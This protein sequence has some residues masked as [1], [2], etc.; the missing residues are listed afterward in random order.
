MERIDSSVLTPQ[1]FYAT[2]CDIGGDVLKRIL[3]VLI[4]EPESSK[5]LRGMIK[6]RR[7]IRYAANEQ[8]CLDL[9]YAGAGDV[10][11]MDLEGEM[12]CDPDFATRLRFIS[13]SSFPIIGVASPNFK[14]TDSWLRAGLAEV[15]YKDRL[16][17][18]SLD[19]TI[20]HW[21]RHQRLQIRLSDANRRALHWWG[22]LVSALDQMRQRMEK[23]SSSL[24]AYLSLLEAAEG[25]IP[26]LRQQT[27]ANARKQLAEIDQLGQ[28]MD[29]AARTIQLEGIEK[30]KDQPTQGRRKVFTTESFV[31]SALKEE[32]RWSIDR[33]KSPDSEEKRRYGT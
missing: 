14:D 31:T 32:Q 1:G 29:V 17:P 20:R 2:L 33:S 27:V 11:L 26:S 15:I 4:A 23:T 6:K 5:F 10:M 25:E 3:Q 30:S 8:E 9:G 24:N 19:R 18:F 21:V 12:G 13:R 16:T 28:D 22:D 7:R